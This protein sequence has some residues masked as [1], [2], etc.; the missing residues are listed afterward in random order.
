MVGERPVWRYRLGRRRIL[1]G[2]WCAWRHRLGRR[3]VLG[4]Y[5]C[6]WLLQALLSAQ[7][8]PR[9]IRRTRRPLTG[10]LASITPIQ[11]ASNRCTTK[12]MAEAGLTIIVQRTRMDRYDRP[13]GHHVLD[14]Q[15][16][17]RGVQPSEIG[18]VLDYRLNH[19]NSI[20]H[21]VDCSM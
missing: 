2:Y 18:E 1:V 5:R 9:L 6:A 15:G 11:P 13:A 3:R 16:R 21:L 10:Q 12:L 19:G 8:Q 17:E 4:G 7:L 20:A 14:L